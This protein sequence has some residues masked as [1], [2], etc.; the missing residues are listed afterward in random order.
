MFAKLLKY[1]CRSVVKYWWIGGVASV[2]FAIL[3]GISLRVANVDY[4]KY[5]GVQVMGYLGM[6]IAYIG[7]LFLPTL[8]LVLMLIR[9][10]KH[11]FTDEGYLTFTLPVKRTALLDSKILT[12][13]IFVGV[14]V[15]I[16]MFDYFLMWFIAE[17]GILASRAI[18]EEFFY[19]NTILWWFYDASGLFDFF[20]YAGGFA[21]TYIILASVIIVLY[22]AAAILLPFICISFA[23]AVTKKHK[24]LAA[25]GIYYGVS[26]AVAFAA[27]LI[28]IGGFATIVDLISKL[29]DI[30]EKTA[31]LFLLVG[32][33]GIL[34]VVISLMYQLLLFLLDKKL[35]L[36]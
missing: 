26:S 31:I 29:S 5:Y 15:L 1:D 9:F 30:P 33:I 28:A 2:F 19:N 14:S 8:A 22:V 23:S 36:E 10:Y 17:P 13:V 34:L 18:A 32:A 12:G 35:N 7:I 3:G 25:I 6:I 20:A 11:F 27:R 24:V 16:V 4:T 21:P